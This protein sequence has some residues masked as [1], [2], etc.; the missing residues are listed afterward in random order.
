[1]HYA[2]VEVK[3]HSQQINYD[4]DNFIPPYYGYTGIFSGYDLLEG[5]SRRHIASLYLQ[6]QYNVSDQLIFTLGGRY[7]HYSDMGDSTTPSLSIL[8]ELN[9]E[10]I[11]K[12]QYAEAFRPPSFNEL[13]TT[14]N[15]VVSGNA[16]L[17]GETIETS[18]VSY[19]F[20]QPERSLRTTLFHSDFEN[21]IYRDGNRYQNGGS[22]WSQG[23]ELELEQ[24]INRSWKV[25]GNLSWIRTRDRDRGG[26]L[27]GSPDWLANLTLTWQPDSRQTVTAHLHHVGDR[28][29][30]AGD[31]RSDLDSYQTLDLTASW[32]GVL[33]DDLLLRA[34]VV[35]LLDESV[36]YPAVANT[37]AADYPQQGRSLWLRLGLSF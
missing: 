24:V 31:S 10:N 30:A 5:K 16:T 26:S 9:E 25:D 22:G 13:Y 8:Y 18:E 2:D 28:S 20:K 7:D 19:M 21:L 36:V 1:M 34:G 15:P 3:R 32:K 27:E 14:N 29:R 17:R 12:A 11:I 37:Y 23:L 6:D 4:P 33:M 35:N